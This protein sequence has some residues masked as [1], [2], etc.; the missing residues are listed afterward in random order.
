GKALWQH[1]ARRSSELK[2]FILDTDA[3]Q[4]YPFD[5]ERV[6][7]DGVS[8]PESEIWSVHPDR[9][10]H[11]VVLCRLSNYGFSD[12]NNPMLTSIWV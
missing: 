2:V 10:K 8:I 12:Q 5:G 7:Y 3:A 1:I 4:Y 11:G 9:S 6:C